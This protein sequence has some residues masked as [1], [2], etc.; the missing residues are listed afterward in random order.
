MDTYAVCVGKYAVPNSKKRILSVCRPGGILFEQNRE[1]RAAGFT[2]VPVVGV[3]E[4]VEASMRKQVD[5]I[6]VGAAYS[7]DERRKLM[8]RINP[9]G[10]IPMLVM[11]WHPAGQ[12]GAGHPVNDTANLLATVESLLAIAPRQKQRARVITTQQA[13]A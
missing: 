8:K 10:V 6:I 13:S 4:A 2:V 1:L 7:E 12:D 9:R 11:R 5:L 3:R